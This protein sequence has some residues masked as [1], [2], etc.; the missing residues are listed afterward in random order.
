MNIRSSI[1]LASTLFLAFAV[2]G[3]NM[4][5]PE[6]MPG[7]KKSRDEGT[8]EKGDLLVEV[9]DTGNIEAAKMVEV[10]SRVGGRLARLLVDEGDIVSAGQLIAV[11]DPQE[12][13]LSVNQQKA[14]LAGAEAGLQ[15]QRIDTGKRRVAIQ[16]NIERMKSRLKQ[17]EMELKNQPALTRA[18]IGSATNSVA[19]QQRALD[20]LVKV[21]QP[22]T[23]TQ[24]QNALADAKNNL[25]NSQYEY[26]RR[27]GLLEKG[28]VSEKDVQAAELSLQLARTRLSE[29]QDRL[30]RL[31]EEQRIERERQ[32]KVLAQSRNEL[33][34]ATVNQFQDKSKEEEYRQ[35]KQQL[36]DA[37]NDLKDLPSLGASERQQAASVQQLKYLV[38]DG[39]RQLG[40]TQIK[41]PITGVVAKRYIQQGE[42][43]TASGSF[44]AGTQIIRIDDR[45]KLLTKLNINEIDVARMQVGQTALMTVDAV[46]E[47]NF[48]GTVTKIAPAQN[49]STGTDAVI[50]YQVEVTFDK[51]DD[52]LKA[53]M[54]A[55]CRI[56]TIDKK[57]VVKIG[58]NFLGTDDKGHFVMLAPANKKDPKSKP[59][60]VDIVIGAKSGTEVEVVSGLKGGEAIVTPSYKG[61]KRQGMMGPGGGD[62][63]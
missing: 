61:P 57:N 51:G 10:K 9:V 42:L 49:T 46:P 37:Q 19:A 31:P 56:H 60:R 29:A 28:Y 43:V 14:Q 34:R 33:D 23:A 35:A 13:Q 2:A 21:T 44:N 52:R 1:T 40:E 45:G 63:E 50:K 6:D 7:A 30:T 27:K 36:I 48:T 8:A 59:T 32:E 54:S 24:V 26:D 53:G 47:V 11:V 17:L 15:R 4:P 39:D 20:Q 25:Q 41:A 16:N 58:I 38:A 3:C 12:T 55:K 62:D 5:K 18:S 22:N